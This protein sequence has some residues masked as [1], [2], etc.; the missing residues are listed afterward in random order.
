MPDPNPR[1][2]SLHRFYRWELLAL[3]FWAFFFH[4]GDRAVFGVVLPQVKTD[5][6][7]TDSQLGMVGSALFLTLALL[8]PLT[9]Y[10]GDVWSRKWIITG[11]LLFWSLATMVT[12]MAR[13]VWGLIAFRSIATA[14][15]EAFYAP[16]AC[17]LMAQFHKRTRALALSI[18]QCSLYL[19]VITSGFLG[20]WIAEQWGWRS[21]FYVF[22]G[23]GLL[24]GFV[25]IFRLDNT[26]FE[27]SETHD[28]GSKNEPI[29]PLD[30]LG[31]IF[32][33]PTARMLTVG[34]TAIVFFNNAYLVW[35]PAFLQQKFQLSLTAAG[36]YSMLY[37]H[38]AAMFAILLGG[39]LSDNMV[40]SRRQFRLELQSVSMLLGVPVIV[41]MGL[42]NDL[43]G[44]LAAMTALGLCRGFYE[45]NTQAS[46]F[47]VIPARYHASAVAM[48]VMVAFLFGSTS[49]WLLGYCSASIS[50][51]CGL[52][53]GF[54]AFSSAYLIGGIAVLV[55]LRRTFNRDYCGE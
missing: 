6:H 50:D 35:A 23:G 36:G 31:V 51:G 24:L 47:D 14:G 55:A 46:M 5:L 45:C 19:G 1:P 53:Y 33:R 16:A 38:L 13:G 2:R 7:L 42:S 10:L 8:M 21:A 37:H 22:G 12:G 11:S 43:T 17:S 44:T 52:S 4:Q 39:R 28:N 29:R 3:L 41:W 25:F 15:G 18:H 26:P 9:G 40:N 49:P 20:G 27:T 34:F 54:A 32:R 30:A 48:M